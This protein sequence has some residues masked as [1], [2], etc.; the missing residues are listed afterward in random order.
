MTYARARL[1]LG[2][3]GVGTTVVPT[4]GVV[5]EQIPQLLLPDSDVWRL[6]D[7]VALAG[8]VM[9]MLPFDVLGGHVLGGHVLPRRHGRKTRSCWSFARPWVLGVI[10]QDDEPERAVW[11]ER[12][13]HPVPSV[14][15]RRRL[16]RS[17]SFGAW[18]ATRM[19]L[20]LSWSCLGLLSRAVHCNAGRPELWVLLPTD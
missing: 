17:R 7:G 8:F 1:W 5:I 15:N 10:V 13:F 19:M 9:F 12:V 14:D 16:T 11:I 4:A 20:F 3:C 18:H 2:I 6:V